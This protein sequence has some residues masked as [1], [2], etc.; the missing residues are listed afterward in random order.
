M[1]TSFALLLLSPI[2]LV[3]LRKLRKPYVQYLYSA[4]VSISQRQNAGNEA[5]GK[6]W[7]ETDLFMRGNVARWTVSCDM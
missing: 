3:L 2:C 7:L 5:N 4:R 1:K 6:I